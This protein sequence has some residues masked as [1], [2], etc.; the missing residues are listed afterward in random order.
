MVS[1]TGREWHS[2]GIDEGHEM[3]INKA[4]KMSIIRPT[5]DYINRIVRYLPYRN[6]AIENF[7]SQLHIFYKCMNPV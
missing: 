2:V 4:C 5:P 1:I 6:K 3:M 7:K